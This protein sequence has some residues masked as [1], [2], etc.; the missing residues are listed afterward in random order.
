MTLQAR[1]Q[2]IRRG[3]ATSNICTNQGLL[4]TA[5]TIYLSL[6]GPQ[7]LREVALQSHANARRLQRELLA[8]PG[9]EPL[10]EGPHF[11]EFGIRLPI[12]ALQLVDAMMAQGILPGLCLQDFVD[13]LVEDAEHALLVAVTEK[14]TQ[15]EIDRYIEVVKTVL[16]GDAS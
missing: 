13:E 2:H 9:V 15:A 1:E 10:F 5:G 3:K 11:H 14:R 8:L 7:G 12:P 4:V 6:V 16:S